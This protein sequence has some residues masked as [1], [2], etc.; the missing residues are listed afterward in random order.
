MAEELQLTIHT[1]L[2]KATNENTRL[3]AKHLKINDEELK[4]KTKVSIINKIAYVIEEGLASMQEEEKVTFLQ[5]IVEILVDTPP[6]LE[7]VNKDKSELLTLKKEI[8]ELKLLHQKMT[9]E[10]ESKLDSA[11]VKQ[12]SNSQSGDG[13]SSSLHSLIEPTSVLRRQ[14]KITGQIGDPDQKDKLN[15]SSL[16]KQIDIAVE[17]KYKENEIVDGVIRAISPGLV[18]R[19]YLE[20][21]KD[22]SLDRLKK[23]LRSHYGVKNTAELYQSLASICQN[24]KETPQAFL[25]RALDLRQKILFASQEGEDTLKY[26]A[27]HIQQLFRRTVETG[28]QDESIRT[29][30]RPHLSNPLI[31]D[32]ELIHQLNVAVSSEE[33]RIKKLKSQ[34]KTKSPVV[35]HIGQE[36][37]GSPEE[38]VGKVPAAAKDSKLPHSTKTELQ[39]LKAEVEALKAEVKARSGATP[40]P[41]QG[42]G[43]RW[44]SGRG[45]GSREVRPRPPKC[46][47]CLT[48]G[49]QWCNHCFKC[50][51]SGHYAIGC[52]YG[53]SSGQRPLNGNRL[54]VRDQK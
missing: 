52:R 29:K 11:K 1:E 9:K 38:P 33:E 17:Q 19:S 6:P 3:V 32:E 49:D 54:L 40:Q 30:L 14:F 15:Y 23:I 16:R 22:L 34:S 42:K 27:D 43:N 12:E 5:A 13:M 28:L 41:D 4:D 8:E 20:S 37:P 36:S 24:G 7:D 21:F 53:E 25:M 39:E 18:L 10:S 50:G 44:S 26:D 31:E 45:Q 48:K 47:A 51:S 35:S 46:S 2:C